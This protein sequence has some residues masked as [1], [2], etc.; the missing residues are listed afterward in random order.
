MVKAMLKHLSLNDQDILAYFTRPTR[1]INHRLIGQIRRGEAH[2]K[3]QE[4]SKDELDAFTKSWP[5]ID[6]ETGLDSR[7]DEKL[8]KSRAA[9]LCA[10]SGFNSGEKYFKTESF[11]VNSIISWTYLIQSYFK[12]IGVDIRHK[13]KK[14]E[15]L[16]TKDGEEK[17][18]ELS[19]LI[20][21]KKCPLSDAEKLNL[22]LLIFLRNKIEHSGEYDI[23]EYLFSYFQSCCQNYNNFVKREFGDQHSLENRLKLAIQFSG[24]SMEQIENTKKIDNN[25]NHVVSAIESFESEIDEKIKSDENYSFKVFFIPRPANNQN[26]SHR[27]IEFIKPGSEEAQEAAQFLLKEV[28]KTKYSAGQVVKIMQE[29][30]FKKFNTYKHSQLWKELDGKNPKH[31]YGVE[32]LYRSQWAWYQKWV[33]RVLAHCEENADTY[34]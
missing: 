6:W 24:F 18:L 2:L 13:N 15:V 11:I 9:M 14:G 31:G 34:K 25:T 22:R 5:L 10:V 7:G 33:D 4:S 29:K 27:S 28:E 30:G 19:S 26:T 17:I 16:K 20:D 8:L 32:G 21:H 1:S 12:K 3:V 23:E